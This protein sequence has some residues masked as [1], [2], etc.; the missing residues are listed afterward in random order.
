M[1]VPAA[2][3]GAGS[4]RAGPRFG[5]WRSPRPPGGPFGHTVGKS[6]P[7]APSAPAARAVGAPGLCSPSLDCAAP[8]RPASARP[9]STAG[10]ALLGCSAGALAA[11]ERGPSRPLPSR[12]CARG[13]RSMSVEA[14]SSG[15]GKR[16]AGPR[17]VLM[18]RCQSRA[19]PRGATPRSPLNGA[20]TASLP[21]TGAPAAHGGPPRRPSAQPSARAPALL[22]PLTPSAPLVPRCA[23]SV[24]CT[25]LLSTPAPGRTS[26]ARLRSDRGRNRPRAA[27]GLAA[28]S[29]RSRPETGHC[30]SVSFEPH[31]MSE[32][33]GGRSGCRGAMQ[34]YWKAP[35]DTQPSH[36]GNKT[37]PPQL[38]PSP[39]LRRSSEK[40]LNLE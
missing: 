1:Q 20:G 21:R 5:R 19:A 34:R 2:R 17:P 4:R 26:G 36:A 33:D 38:A 28:V 7:L 6:A 39:R 18:P 27:T 37:W 40:N 3:A 25:A 13:C 16:R 15:P 31:Q 10:T 30:Q 32:R 29:G 12:P 9:A 11:K 35:G 8:A 24:R 23:P 14:A 22:V